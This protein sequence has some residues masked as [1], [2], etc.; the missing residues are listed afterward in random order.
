MEFLLDIDGCPTPIDVKKGRSN[1]NSLKEFR[2]H[3]SNGLAIKISSN[4]YGYDKE[5]NLLTLPL[6][7]LSFY[8][9]KLQKGAINEAE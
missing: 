4:Q 6:Y 2:A 9:D 5:T 3:N 8:L 7:Y 1:L